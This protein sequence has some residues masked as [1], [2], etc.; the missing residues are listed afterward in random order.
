MIL[1]GFAATGCIVGLLSGGSPRGVMRYT[2]K[3][4]WLPIAAYALKAG[5]ALLLAPQTGAVWVALLQYGLLF[6]FFFVNRRRPVWPLFAFAGTL[7]NFLVI[8]FNGGCMPVSV[9]LL[10][11]AGERL[12]QLS[13]GRIYAYRLMDAATRLPFF[14]DIIRFGSADRPLGFASIG[15]L[16]LG[17]GVAILC[18]QMMKTDQKTE[19]SEPD[20]T[21][22]A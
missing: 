8:V 16:L 14:G 9:S 22:A 2:L 7:C 19:R 11:A 18:W 1:L 12:T 10:S 3:G 4:V 5:A 13:E 6:L 15:D 21:K 17:I 20:R